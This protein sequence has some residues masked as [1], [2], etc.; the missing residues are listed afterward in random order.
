MLDAGNF[1]YV[2]Q[3][4]LAHGLVAGVHSTTDAVLS[5]FHIGSLQQQPGSTG[6]TEVEGKRAIGADGDT[7][8]NRDAGVDVGG[9]SVEFLCNGKKFSM[10]LRFVG[11]ST[12]AGSAHL[13]KV[14][15]LHTFTT[16]GGTD[17]GTGTGLAGAHDE[18][19]D[20]ILG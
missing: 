5:R 17:R 19:H 13:A 11:E 7:R 16:Q 10:S 15:T 4:D 18:L 8:R 2:L 20:L 12:R 9:T 1:V 6:G 14:H 3:R